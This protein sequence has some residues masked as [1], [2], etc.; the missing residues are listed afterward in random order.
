LELLPSY[1]EAALA[2]VELERERRRFDEAIGVLVDLLSL[3]P[4][5]LEALALLG[6]VLLE[7]G[8]P[9]DAATAFRRILRFD[10]D[11]A[12]AREGLARAEGAVAVASEG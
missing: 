6:W 3:D 5:H 12:D 8:R 2:L 1:G 10:P 11:H 4:Y 9:A 7:A